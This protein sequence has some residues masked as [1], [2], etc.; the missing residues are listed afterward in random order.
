VVLK[1]S[2]EGFVRTGRQQSI[3]FFHR[4]FH[5]VYFSLEIV[6]V[7][8]YAALF[9]DGWDRYVKTSDTFEQKLIQEALSTLEAN[10]GCIPIFGIEAV[11]PNSRN[12]SSVRGASH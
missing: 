3:K 4:L 10:R 7:G 9:G 8:N 11:A 2:L 6:K 5:F 1:L 12:F